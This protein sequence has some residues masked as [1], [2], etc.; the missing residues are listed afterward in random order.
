MCPS[1]LF[2]VRSIWFYT[3][4]VYQCGFVSALNLAPPPPF[5]SNNITKRRDEMKLMYYKMFSML[6]SLTKGHPIHKCDKTF[7]IKL[8][9]FISNEFSDKNLV[10]C[11]CLFILFGSFRIFFMHHDFQLVWHKP[12]IPWHSRSKRELLRKRSRDDLKRFIFLQVWMI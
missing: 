9:N 5:H 11:L 2:T 8:L 6:Q 1:T 7:D 10:V 3:L 4:N 12:I